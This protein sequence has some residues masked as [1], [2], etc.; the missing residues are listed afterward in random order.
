MKRVKMTPRQ[1]YKEILEDVGMNY[2]TIDGS[3][4]WNEDFAYELTI[5]EVDA[6]EDA[7]NDLVEMA[8][9]LID[10]IV[11]KDDYHY[12][13]FTDIEKELIEK[14]WRANQPSIYGRFDLG[15]DGKQIKLFE[16]NADTPTG[17]LEAAVCQWQWLKD[18]ELPDQFNSIHEELVERWRN[19]PT[20]GKVYFTTNGS[21]SNEDWANVHYMMS[22]SYES[23]KPVSSINLEEIGWDTE[24]N[25]FVDVNLHEMTDVFKLYPWEWMTKDEF[26]DH[27]VK[28]KTVFYEPP[29]RMLMSNKAFLIRMWEMF[30]NNKY[31]LSAKA[32]ISE[33][34][35]CGKWV[36]KPKIGRE[37]QGIRVLRNWAHNSHNDTTS[38][39]QR[40]F[41][42]PKFD[43]LMPVIGSWVVGNKSVGIGIR[44]GGEIT[45]NMSMFVPHYFVED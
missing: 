32:E 23:G 20:G 21:A 25:N 19:T 1:N 33:Y 36:V 24:V 28:S 4:Y 9:H 6:I 22:T 30:P 26:A 11:S 10:N 31:L 45:D 18:K 12:Y 5:D 43:G 15:Y 14:S 39:V 8:N 27:I 42:I 34:F 17:L 38:I 40:R 13:D 3:K 2:H 29:W 7:T 37:G 16:F 41:K 44:E 35:S